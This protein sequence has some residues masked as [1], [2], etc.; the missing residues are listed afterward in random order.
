MTPD[1]DDGKSKL[2]YL[3]I[4]IYDNISLVNINAGISSVNK[5]LALELA[6]IIATQSQ[7][8]ISSV[9]FDVNAYDFG[10]RSYLN[11][12]TIVNKGRQLKLVKIFVAFTSL[13]FS[14]NHFEGPMPEEIMNFKALHA[15]NLSKNAFSGHIPSSVGN[16]RHL[17][18]LDL[19]MNSFG[20][21]IPSELASLNFLAFLNLSYNH[22]IGLI[23]IGTQIQSF[24][25]DSFKGNNHLCG[26][27]LTPNCNFDDV[28]GLLTP[29]SWSKTSNGS[30]HGS[31]IDWNF[32]SAGLGF[33]FGLGIIIFPIIFCQQ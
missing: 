12:V 21:R 14:S 6:K 19:S 29:T 28:L 10:C 27:P 3:Y 11:S 4:D 18:S 16:L 33:T 8:V 22:L 17:E 30:N 5:D 20:G 2:G 26:P 9:F 15:L 32:L 7:S 25:A 13:D 1:E 31:D 23:P 24:E